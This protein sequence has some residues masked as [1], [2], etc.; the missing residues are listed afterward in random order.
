[1]IGAADSGVA[2]CEL[3][4]ARPSCGGFCF[5]HAFPIR[6]DIGTEHPAISAHHAAPD[7]WNDHT[8]VH[9]PL[10]LAT[11]GIGSRAHSIRPH[12]REV[13]WLDRVAIVATTQSLEASS[14]R[15][16][17]DPTAANPK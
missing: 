15:D 8:D 11:H 5:L 6:P 9:D 14:V 10:V 4:K 17:R 16:Q 13:H 1:M 12:V 2:Q 3:Q 7:R